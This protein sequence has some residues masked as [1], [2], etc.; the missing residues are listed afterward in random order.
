MEEEEE[1]ED[2]E[3]AAVIARP[4]P[5]SMRTLVP[6]LA[7]MRGVDGIRGR[8]TGVMVEDA[9]EALLCDDPDED[10]ELGAETEPS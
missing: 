4:P 7:L 3:G 2:E 10:V 1:E 5:R 9:E 8:G 6:L